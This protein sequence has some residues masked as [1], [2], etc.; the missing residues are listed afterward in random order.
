MGL[1]LFSLAYSV[2]ASC[3][4]FVS[5]FGGG[6]AINDAIWAGAKA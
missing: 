4:S 6:A 2:E 5:V 1:S 3:H